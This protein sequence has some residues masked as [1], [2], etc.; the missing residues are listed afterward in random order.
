M[1][2]DRTTLTEPLALVGRGI[3]VDFVPHSNGEDVLI[4]TRR[5][6]GL[7]DSAWGFAE[8]VAFHRDSGMRDTDEP[9]PVEAK[10]IMDRRIHEAD[11]WEL[12]VR[13]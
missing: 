13:R 6:D 1:A 7:Y 4:I 9:M 2:K 12:P 5:R 3:R 10:A 8:S 11:D